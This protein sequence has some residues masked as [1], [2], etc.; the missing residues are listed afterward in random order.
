M[1]EAIRK[2]VTQQRYRVLEIQT[3]TDFSG[4]LCTELCSHPNL[5]IVKPT[6]VEFAVCQGNKLLVIGVFQFH[7]NLTR[8]YYWGKDANE[9]VDAN[10]LFGGP[11]IEA[12]QQA[13]LEWFEEHQDPGEQYLYRNGQMFTGVRVK[14]RDRV[15]FN[16]IKN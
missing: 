6:D 11:S 16:P 10:V 14:I 4:P 2:Y 9:W 1:L 12:V 15:L 8:Q 5:S 7:V 3:T 13:A